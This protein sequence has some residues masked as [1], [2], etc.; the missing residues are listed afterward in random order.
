MAPGALMKRSDARLRPP[1]AP[2]GQKRA[3]AVRLAYAWS[4]VKRTAGAANP[5]AGKEQAPEFCG[6]P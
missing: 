6:C 5:V 4:A 1:H 3:V 2:A